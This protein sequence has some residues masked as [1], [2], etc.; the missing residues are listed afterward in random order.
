MN[1]NESVNQINTN[2]LKQLGSNTT[3]YKYDEPEVGILEVF[4]S[5]S[6]DYTVIFKSKEFTSLCPKTGQPDY[7][8]IIVVMSPDGYCIESK[9]FKLYLFAYRN[10]KGFT[11]QIVNKIAADIYAACRPLSVWVE[12]KF[13]ARGGVEI[14]VKK[15]IVK[16]YEYA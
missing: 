15:L 13:A 14:Q 10:Y 11:E 2:H 12:G 4:D 9:S 1:Q 7:G 8:E 3:D 16:K 6:K 5:P